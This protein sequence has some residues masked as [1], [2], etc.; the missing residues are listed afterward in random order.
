MAPSSIPRH[1]DAEDAETVWYNAVYFPRLK[2]LEERLTHIAAALR[3]GV[4]QEARTLLT[5]RL[6]RLDD[7]LVQLKASAETRKPVY[8]PD[9]SPEPDSEWT[10]RRRRR[11]KKGGR[12]GLHKK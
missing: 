2:Y 9:L 11:R 4:D 3:N 7:E 8:A 12:R 6:Q 5:A 1:F 10:K